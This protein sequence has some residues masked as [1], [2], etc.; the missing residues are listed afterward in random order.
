MKFFLDSVATRP[1]P[2]SN[3]KTV[4]AIL[5]LSAPAKDLQYRGSLCYQAP[6]HNAY[7]EQFGASVYKIQPYIIPSNILL[8]SII[9]G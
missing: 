8:L 7:I 6:V 5:D 3:R 9:Y 1:S 2:R 4:H